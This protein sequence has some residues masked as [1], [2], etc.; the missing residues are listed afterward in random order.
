MESL[1]K[2]TDRATRNCR[3]DRLREVTAQVKDLERQVASEREAKHRRIAELEQEVAVLRAQKDNAEQALAACRSQL[4]ESKEYLR[5]S[6]Q[7]NS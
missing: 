3:C 6:L 5:L 2:S 4:E 1:A 7:K